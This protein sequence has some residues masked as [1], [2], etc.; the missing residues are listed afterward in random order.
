MTE[1]K[2]TGKRKIVPITPLKGDDSATT[3]PPSSSETIRIPM[4]SIRNP[5]QK[6]ALHNALSNTLHR[7]TDYSA[8][9]SPTSSRDT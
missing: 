3:T 4:E 8:Q 7:C 6:E 9:A 2:K 5:C 1:V